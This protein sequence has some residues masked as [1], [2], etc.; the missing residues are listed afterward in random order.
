MKKILLLGSGELGKELTIS[1]QRLGCEII[2]CDA[3]AN[4]PAMQVADHSKVFNMLDPSMLQ[5]VV[6]ETN[7]DFIVPEIE[8][9]RTE[10]LLKL[11]KK[12]FNIVPSAKAVNLTMNRDEIR[13]RA[14]DLGIRTA[15]YKY[16]HNIEELTN[17]TQIIG[18]SNVLLSQ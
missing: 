2:A 12:G 6:Q 8:A 7:P 4:A 16:A 14:T 15:K 18:F 3:Y 1:A 5:K 17:A 13:N 10:E 11:E 9:I